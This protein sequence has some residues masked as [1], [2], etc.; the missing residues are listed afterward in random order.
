[1]IGVINYGL[2]N[3][4][5]VISAFEEIGI[6]SVLLDNPEQVNDNIKGLVIPGVG[7][8]EE[9]MNKLDES[10]WK[11]W[12]ISNGSSEIPVLG[13]CLGMQLF[14]DSSEESPGT[15]GLGLI[16]GCIGALKPGKE[17]IPNM[18]WR[19]VSV[20]NDDNVLFRDID[21]PKFYHVHS[22]GLKK[23]NHNSVATIV[24]NS[25][26]INVAVHFNRIF[27][28]QFHPEKSLNQ[29]LKILDN[30]YQFCNK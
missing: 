4:S 30:Y 24:F 9:G 2:G 26:I 17:P 29:G 8:F 27:G 22:F 6:E 7:S 19:R 3:S 20:D 10:G 23:I 25:E 11:K 14:F 12:L 18:G 15:A 13:I 21:T 5:S 28:I 1:M 16:R